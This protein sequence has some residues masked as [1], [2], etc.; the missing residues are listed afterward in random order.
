MAQSDNTGK[1]LRERRVEQTRADIVTTAMSLFLEQ[2]Y[3]DT[4]MEEVAVATGVSR[5]TLYRYFASKDDIVF[6]L[7]RLW[8]QHVREVV[9]TRAPDESTRSV[10][11]RAILDVVVAMEADADRVLG[12]LQLVTS[13]ETLQARRGRSDAEWIEY[14]L[15]LILPDVQGAAD[16]LRQAL[17][18][19][20]ALV[21][22]QNAMLL[23]WG[24]DPSQSGAD[25][26]DATL[27]QLDSVWPPAC[28]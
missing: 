2:G 11:R 13:S 7:P 18:C 28:R 12:G 26:A 23:A 24:A 9:D 15:G 16:G 25:L 1:T 5:R 8:L 21:A 3:D 17:V 6:E 20:T 27:D 22:G 4:S 10:L 14:Y 19:A